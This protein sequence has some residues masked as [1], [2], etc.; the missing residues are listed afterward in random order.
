MPLSIKWAKQSAAKCFTRCYS[1]TIGGGDSTPGRKAQMRKGRKRQIGEHCSLSTPFCICICICVL[2]EQTNYF[3]SS[4]L[5]HSV[6]TVRLNCYTPVSMQ[7]RG[8]KPLEI[9]LSPT[10]YE[11]GVCKPKTHKIWGLI[12]LARGN[13]CNYMSCLF[14]T[15]INFFL[16]AANVQ[17]RSLFGQTHL[18]P[19]KPLICLP[20]L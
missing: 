6:T 18:H 20:P 9:V 16:P 5:T 11:V 12:F 13:S 14:C 19:A 10:F 8:G 17:E 3:S 15:F 4:I 1:A 2:T 7:F